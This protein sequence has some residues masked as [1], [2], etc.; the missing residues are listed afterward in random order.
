MGK[1]ESFSI[2]HETSK[3]IRYKLD[4]LNHNYID[5]DILKHYFKDIS[6][7]EDVRINKRAKCIVFNLSKNHIGVPGN[8]K[9]IE[10]SLNPKTFN[11]NVSDFLQKKLHL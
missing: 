4:I 2:I 3:R 9:K 8:L 1:K 6:G 11:I 10:M 5:E 7:I